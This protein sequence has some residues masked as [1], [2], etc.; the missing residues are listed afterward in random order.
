MGLYG[1]VYTSSTSGSSGDRIL[2]MGGGFSSGNPTRDQHMP[3]HLKFVSYDG[4]IVV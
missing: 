2:I 1:R 3:A 4:S